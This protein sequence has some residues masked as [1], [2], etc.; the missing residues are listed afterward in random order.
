MKLQKKMLATIVAGTV[1]AL[2]LAGCSAAGVEKS[3][4]ASP[5]PAAVSA[6][7]TPS[8]T[9]TI[10]AQSVPEA[11]SIVQT[12]QAADDEN[13]TAV[14]GLLFTDPQRA[15]ESIDGVVD[16][17][18]ASINEVTNEEVKSAATEELDLMRVFA[19]MV[20]KYGKNALNPDNPEVA[21]LQAAKDAGPSKFSQLCPGA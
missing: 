1:L 19:S 2:T 10:P 6:E 5:K 16:R 15:G 21:T 11:C 4:S 13:Y 20:H 3:E 12:V 9:P 7:P 14:L 17:L 18:A 8:E